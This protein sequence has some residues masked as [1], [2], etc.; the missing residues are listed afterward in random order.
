M[1]KSDKILTTMLMLFGIVYLWMTYQIPVG[2]F[3]DPMGPRAFPF[4]LGTILVLCTLVLIV[5]GYRKQKRASDPQ[6]DDRAVPASLRLIVG[7]AVWS[8]FYVFFFESLG[9]LLATTIYILGLTNW[10]YR[11]HILLNLIISVGFT[12]ISYVLFVKF[13]GAMLPMGVI[14]L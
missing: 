12:L 13:L 1:A 11:G 4:I 9:Y 6:T 10:L 8:G 5:Q 2:S 14:P 3:G 7:I